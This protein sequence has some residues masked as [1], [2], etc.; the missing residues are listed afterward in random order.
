MVRLKRLKATTLVESMVAMTLIV[1]SFGIGMSIHLNVLNG[2]QVEQKTQAHALL[3][4][5][6]EGSRKT[7]S[8]EEET[9]EEGGML[10]TK[11]F[12]PYP[13]F[14]NAYLLEL[15]AFDGNSNFIT[16][17]KEVIYLPIQ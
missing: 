4:N 16:E 10:V 12:S 6:L 11:A 17:V 13:G 14:Q 8:F 1:V 9:I 7:M 2:S 3:V 5:V 15:K